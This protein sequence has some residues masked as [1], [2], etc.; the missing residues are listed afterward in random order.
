MDWKNIM[1]ADVW[2][3]RIFISEHQHSFK[4]TILLK[5]WR[6]STQLIYSTMFQTAHACLES[7]RCMCWSTKAITLRHRVWPFLAGPTGCVFTT[8]KEQK[9]PFHLPDDVYKF[10]PVS[11][12]CCYSCYCLAPLTCW[13][14]VGSANV[15]T[16]SFWCFAPRP[17][18]GI[19][20]TCDGRPGDPEAL[21]CMKWC[22]RGKR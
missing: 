19:A 16:W 14:S 9:K 17:G 11:S 20:R 1:C 3:S 6:Q 13:S 5:A 8:F 10:V 21:V 2:Q 22:T 7:Q 12:L 15:G 18:S 4:G